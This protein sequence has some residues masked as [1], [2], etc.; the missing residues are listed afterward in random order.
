[1]SSGT[2]I[3]LLPCASE[4]ST[5]AISSSIAAQVLLKYFITEQNGPVDAVRKGPSSCPLS[6]PLAGIWMIM[7]LFSFAL[8][9]PFAEAGSILAL[10]SRQNFK[11]RDNDRR[12]SKSYIFDFALSHNIDS[13]SSLPDVLSVWLNV[14]IKLDAVESK[15]VV[16]GENEP[17]SSHNATGVAKLHAQGIFGKGAK[18]GVVGNTGGTPIGFELGFKVAEA[19]LLPATD[20]GPTSP[21][22]RA[23]MNLMRMPSI[24]KAAVSH[25]AVFIAAKGVG[26]GVAPESKL[27]AFPFDV[28]FSRVSGGNDETS[29][30]LSTP[31]P[32]APP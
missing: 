26:S 30:F 12:I 32:P 14:A 8:A 11:F 10:K 13:L 15:R 7:W 25:A 9:L 31:A 3:E 17:Y 6:S 16:E 2:A 18:A 20:P 21:S 19:M 4:P 27:P 28:T 1:M 23:E 5:A 29:L 22:T 24:S